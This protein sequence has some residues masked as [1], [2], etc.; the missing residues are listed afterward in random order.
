[1]FSKFIGV[2][3]IYYYFFYKDSLYIIPSQGLEG[4]QSLGGE[5]QILPTLILHSPDIDLKMSKEFQLLDACANGKLSDIA[6]LLDDGVDVLYQDPKDG[7]SA[8]MKAADGSQLEAVEM[9]LSAGC[10][11]NLQDHE[12]YTA[13]SYG[14]QHGTSCH[15][16]NTFLNPFHMLCLPC[17]LLPHV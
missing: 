9:L 3:K 4:S 17:Y 2:V 11:W 16:T 5:F 10:P 7:M 13:G 15:R 8:L 1:L 6:R 12:G 14:R